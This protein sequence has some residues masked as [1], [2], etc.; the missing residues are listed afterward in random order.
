MVHDIN[1]NLHSN[2]EE[3]CDISAVSFLIGMCD[4]GWHPFRDVLIVLGFVF[5]I[6]SIVLVATVPFIYTQLRGQV[7]VCCKKCK[8]VF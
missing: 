8:K 5:S 3:R 7:L 4:Q 1:I 2:S 6:L